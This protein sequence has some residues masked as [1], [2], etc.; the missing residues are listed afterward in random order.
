MR[1]GDDNA[2]DRRPHDYVGFP[3]P[4]ESARA[5]NDRDV[6]Q[7][8]Y[9]ANPEEGEKDPFATRCEARSARAQHERGTDDEDEQRSQQPP[10]P[11]REPTIR[12]A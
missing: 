8:G 9:S 1:D 6:D 4:R 12:H 3:R 5:R 2:H 10:A 7:S 11:I